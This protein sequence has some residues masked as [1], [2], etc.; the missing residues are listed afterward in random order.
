MILQVLNLLLMAMGFS[1]RKW[2]SF[3][4]LY[5]ILDDQQNLKW[6]FRNTNP[7]HLKSLHLRYDNK[8]SVLNRN[9]LLTPLCHTYILLFPNSKNSRFQNEAKCKVFL[10][11]MSIISASYPDVS[12]SMKMCAQRKAGR[13]FPMVPCGSSP[14]TPVSRSPLRRDKRSA[15]GGGW[16]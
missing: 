1:K 14:V 16:Y 9:K 11:I 15:W 3:F 13:T 5:I 7:R 6:K 2:C 4:L 10:V 12:L 8:N